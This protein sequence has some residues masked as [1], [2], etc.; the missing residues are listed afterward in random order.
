MRTRQGRIGQ[1]ADAL[2]QSLI[3]VDQAALETRNIQ[4]HPATRSPDPCDPAMADDDRSIE[5]GA[6][7]LAQLRVRGQGDAICGKP[8]RNGNHSSL[9]R[10]TKR[11][12]R[13]SSSTARPSNHDLTVAGY[14]IRRASDRSRQDAQQFGA[15]GLVPKES[16][17]LRTSVGLHSFG[18]TGDATAIVGNIDPTEPSHPRRPRN[19]EW[20]APSL[21][22]EHHPGGRGSTGQVGDT[23]QNADH[24]S[25]ITRDGHI[26]DRPQI[27]T[28]VRHGLQDLQPLIR[29]PSK[30][31]GLHLRSR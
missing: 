7:R 17:V 22:P 18:Q 28:V 15:F 14:R 16:L 3:G 19:H 11:L 9:R 1:F 29:A 31:L 21:V 20:V 6:Q 25:S 13:R 26:V 5:I 23:G 8:L 27:L 10:P 2:G 30:R 24:D 4:Q 12:L